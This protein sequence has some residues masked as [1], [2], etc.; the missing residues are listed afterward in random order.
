M[1]NKILKNLVRVGAAVGVVSL[2]TLLAVQLLPTMLAIGL[3]LGSLVTT[4]MVRAKLGHFISF[5]KSKIWK[6]PSR[7]RLS[8]KELENALI[9]GQEKE[10][11]HHNALMVQ[12]KFAGHYLAQ[13]LSR[14]KMAEAEQQWLK[15][16]QQNQPGN[17]GVT[18]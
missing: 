10:L 17:H 6:L 16:L 5:L 15:R 9:Y 12:H 11:E 8:I 4:P 7:H 14:G 18:L 2:T 1:K 3:G 13:A